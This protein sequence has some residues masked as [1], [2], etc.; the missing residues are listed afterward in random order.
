MVIMIYVAVPHPTRATRP[1]ARR[2]HAPES[3]SPVMAQTPSELDE[4]GRTTP[5]FAQSC[6]RAGK[7]SPERY[8]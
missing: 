5:A 6:I 4:T 7:A 1:G 2:C 3:V 8:L